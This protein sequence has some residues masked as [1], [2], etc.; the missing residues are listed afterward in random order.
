MYKIC[1]LMRMY[2]STEAHFVETCKIWSLC[3]C[4]HHNTTKG[5][6]S[7]WT[8]SCRIPSNSR[9]ILMRLHSG[10][11]LLVYRTGTAIQAP[12]YPDMPTYKQMLSMAFFFLIKT[13]HCKLGESFIKLLDPAIIKNTPH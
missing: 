11:S 8:R 6:R 10:K 7:S 5:L 13:P 2:E 1:L 3:Y 12:I 4:L 9:E